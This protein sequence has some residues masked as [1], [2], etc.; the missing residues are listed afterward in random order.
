MPIGLSRSAHRQAALPRC[1]SR[2]RFDRH[3]GGLPCASP[4]MGLQ[5]AKALEPWALLLKNPVGRRVRDGLAMINCS[6]LHADHTERTDHPFRRVRDLFAARACNVSWISPTAVGSQPPD[7]RPRR[8]LPYAV[9]TT[10]PRDLS[11]PPRPL[12][13]GFSPASYIIYGPSSTAVPC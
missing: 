2:W 3:H 1:A 4:A 12:E 8:C 6:G 9:G 5:F 7:R 13:F 10:D 11:V